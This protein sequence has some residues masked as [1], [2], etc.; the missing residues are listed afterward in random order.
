[1]ERLQKN[2]NMTFEDITPAEK[3]E[4]EAA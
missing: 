1:M 4:E 3:P 2:A